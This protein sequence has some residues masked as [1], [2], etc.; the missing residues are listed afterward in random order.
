VTPGVGGGHASINQAQA[1]RDIIAVAGDLVLNMKDRPPL[2]LGIPPLP[3]QFE[4]RDELLADLIP[5]LVS[6]QT[7]ALSAEGL[8]GVGKTTMAVVLAYHKEV[9][10]HFK[11]GVLWAS[12]GP[13]GDPLRLLGE[14]AEGLGEDVSD[15]VTVAERQRAVT[16]LLGQQRLL[17]VID[18]AWNAEAA[19][20]LYCGG[21]HCVYLLTTRDKDIAR[22]FAGAAHVVSVPELAEDPAF[23]LLQKLAPEACAVD[24]AAA[25]ALTQ[26]V[27]GLP[28][29]LELLGGFLARPEHLAFADLSQQ[30]LQE[31]A[32]PAARLALASRRLGSLEG[33]VTLADTIQLSLDTLPEKAV[34]AFSALGA[35]APKPESFGRAAAEVVAETDGG[36]LALLHSRN[37]VEIQEERLALH[38]TLADFARQTV[39]V[40]AAQQR[41]FDF[42]L[43]L[44]NEDRHN[45]RRIKRAYPQI[46]WAWAA[47]GKSEQK[48]KLLYSLWTYQSRQGLWPDYISWA[49]ECLDLAQEYGQKD[50]QASFLTYLGFAYDSLGQRDKALDYYQQA[51]PISEEVG[52][53]AGLATTL[54]NI[55]L[56]YNRL[57]QRDKALDYYNQALPISEEVGNRAG[58]ASTLNNIGLVYNRLGQ[59]DK[60]LDYYNQALPISEEVGDRAGLATTLNNI[61]SVYDSLGQRDKALDYYQQAL[62]ISEEVG[63][64][65]GLATTLNNIG[66]VYDSLGQRDKALDYYQQ[67]LPIQEEVGDRAGL[68]TT[69]TNIGLVYDRLGQRDKALDYYQQALAISQEV[70]DRAGLATTLNNI[71]LVYN[72]LGQ[73]DKALDYYQ[74]ALAISQEVGDRAGLATT[75]NNIG[76]V[77]DSLSQRDKALDYFQQALAISQEVGDR[78]GLATTLNNIGLVYD[79][80]GQRDKALDYY[81]QALP[82]QEEVGD[83]D[84]LA[85]TLNNIGLVY[86]S[87]GQRDKALDY[88][89][90]ALPIQEEVG[91]R[92]GERVTRYNIAMV[93][94]A[95]WRLAAAITQLKR[96]RKLE[97]LV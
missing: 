47:I 46:L 51:L 8:P 39:D 62:P 87:L 22:S 31:L 38:Q 93:Y 89:N 14:W 45:W 83:R 16:R 63:D 67:A 50:R 11:D 70:G 77:Y 58:L 32:D 61:G 66:S 94:L 64:R 25:R 17:L 55:G 53:R 9:L 92:D 3:P 56:V 29:A 37:L 26:A 73:R 34:T 35:F 15:L 86:D 6:G 54:N 19:K 20:A 96:V 4:G 18:D 23:T 43:A 68:A 71:G 42:Y 21:P 30:A 52:D 44:A 28:L 72:R 78:A 85:T 80:L 48:Y 76:G 5:R 1:G 90:Q 81:N 88:Y 65:A 59:R 91:D 49:Q 24:P 74:Q 84:G 75:L 36:T 27:G 82:I 2:W 41:H 12:L 40:T 79:S 13:T 57:G 69:L 7:M 33:S 60:A 95:Q 10:S 97:R